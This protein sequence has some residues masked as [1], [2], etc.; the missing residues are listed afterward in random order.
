MKSLICYFWTARAKTVL[1]KSGI[2]A[3]VL[4]CLVEKIIVAQSVKVT[5]FR[6][7]QEESRCFIYIPTNALIVERDEKT[8][9]ENYSGLGDLEKRTALSTTT[10]YPIAPLTKS[11]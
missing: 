2:L 6:K 10:V 7:E 4:F 3:T 1:Q 11:D 8:I 5:K 9:F